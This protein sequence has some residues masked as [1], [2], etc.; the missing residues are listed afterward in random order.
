MT[1]TVAPGTAIRGQPE[2]HLYFHRPLQTLLG[3]CFAQGFVFDALEEHAF[4]PDHPPGNNPLSWGG[5][6]SE[7]PPVLVARTRLPK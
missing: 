6:F 4:P 2:P 1:S 5:N 7:I 3:A